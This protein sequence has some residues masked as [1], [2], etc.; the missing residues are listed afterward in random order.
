MER[1]LISRHAQREQAPREGSGLLSGR[2]NGIEVIRMT[3]HSPAH[4]TAHTCLSKNPLYHPWRAWRSVRD[5][6]IRR[7]WPTCTSLS[8]IQGARVRMTEQTVSY[9]AYQ[10]PC[11]GL[12]AQI[13][14]PS[15]T[16]PA[17]AESHPHSGRRTALAAKLVAGPPAGIGSLPK[18]RGRARDAS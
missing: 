13:Q 12:A 1:H 17:S 11:I 18:G 5:S 4:V 10:R 9:N 2:A 16:I 15:V 14:G 6:S 3:S 8:Q 7:L